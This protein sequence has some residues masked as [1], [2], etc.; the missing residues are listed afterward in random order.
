MRRARTGR[1]AVNQAVAKGCAALCLLLF[2][3]PADASAWHWRPPVTGSPVVI[4]TVDVRDA[5][6]ALILRASTPDTTWAP[7]P[8]LDHVAH[9]VTVVGIDDLLREGPPSELSDPYVPSEWVGLWW[10]MG[11]STQTAPLS[12][13]V[14]GLQATSAAWPDSVK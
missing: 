3:L 1:G 10:V 5:W 13:V 11:A 2:L 8:W 7:P 4:Y 9:R 6:G 14:A 12:M